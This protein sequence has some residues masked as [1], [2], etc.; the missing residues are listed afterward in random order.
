MQWA[1]RP[2]WAQVSEKCV[3]QN[4]PNPVIGLWTG[5]TRLKKQIVAALSFLLTPKLEGV[6]QNRSLTAS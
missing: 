5:C 3:C 1:K 2:V 6:Q 4:A